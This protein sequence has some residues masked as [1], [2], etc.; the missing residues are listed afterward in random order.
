MLPL[1][2]GEEA[3][4]GAEEGGREDVGSSE[5]QD[6]SS[7]PLELHYT[8]RDAGQCS[9]PSRAFFFTEGGK[10]L[11]ERGM[12]A[13]LAWAITVYLK[14]FFSFLTQVCHVPA[15]KIA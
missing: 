14:S 2:G 4:K 6:F 1:N 7:S 11:E 9:L 12:R 15:L 3:R 10:Y 5:C 8:A 13:N